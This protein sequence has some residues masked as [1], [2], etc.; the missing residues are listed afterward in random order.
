MPAS[1]STPANPEPA[2]PVEFRVTTYWKRRRNEPGLTQMASQRIV[3]SEALDW[4]LGE[5]PDEALTLEHDETGRNVVI[6]ICWDL[7]PGEIRYGRRS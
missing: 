6:R 1:P 3:L 2:V 5:L 4:V 7:V